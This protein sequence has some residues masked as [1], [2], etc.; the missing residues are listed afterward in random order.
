MTVTQKKALRMILRKMFKMVGEK[1]THEKTE[2]ENWYTK[3]GWTEEEQNEF[4]EWL[5]LKILT[6]A[7]VKELFELRWHVDKVIAEKKANGFVF[8]YGW[9]ILTED[10]VTLKKLEALEIAIAK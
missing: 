9:R 10:E 8:N 5:T 6:D 1:Y 2:V 3:H 7:H 4:K